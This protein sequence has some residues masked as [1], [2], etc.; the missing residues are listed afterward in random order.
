MKAISFDYCK[1]PLALPCI[2]LSYA[3]GIFQKQTPNSV[4]DV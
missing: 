4:P 2:L 3:T 1:S